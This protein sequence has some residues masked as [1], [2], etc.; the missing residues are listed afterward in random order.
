MAAHLEA[1]PQGR[2]GEHHYAFDDLGVDRAEVE[3]GFAR[4]VEHFQVPTAG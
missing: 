3:R 2:H 1:K 4:Y